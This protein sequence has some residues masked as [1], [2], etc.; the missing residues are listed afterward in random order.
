[1]VVNHSYTIAPNSSAPDSD[2]ITYLGEVGSAAANAA[3]TSLAIP[4]GP[5]GVAAGNT[6]IVGFAS[7]G[8]PNYAEP[9]VTDSRGNTYNLANYAVTYQHGRAYLFY[10]YI[11]EALAEGDQ[12]TITTSSVQSRVAVAAAFGG[13]L[14]EGVLDQTLA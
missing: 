12:I 5:A 10:S 14:A 2:E 1:G 8:D 6:V 9:V 11:E 4:V 3:G 7:R 13:L